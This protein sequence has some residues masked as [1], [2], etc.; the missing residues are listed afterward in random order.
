MTIRSDKQLQEENRR[1]RR[2]LASL[3]IHSEERRT[4]ETLGQEN[5]RLREDLRWYLHIVKT[6]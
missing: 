6:I 5:C 4:N 1:L 3:G 2:R